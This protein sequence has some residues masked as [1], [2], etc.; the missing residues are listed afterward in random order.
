MLL[1]VC[2]HRCIGGTGLDQQHVDAAAGQPML[3]ALCIA[4]HQSL[5]G[6]IDVIGFA[7]PIAR[8]RP[9][10]GDGTVAALQHDACQRL[11]EQH[12]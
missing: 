9:D 6:A 3:Q 4:I 12:G 7:T 8:H 2:R 11:S 1:Q 10:D 5:G